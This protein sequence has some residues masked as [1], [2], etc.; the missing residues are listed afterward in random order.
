MGLRWLIYFFLA[1]F[2]SV[3]PAQAVHWF[4]LLPMCQHL[5]TPIPHCPPITDYISPGTLHNSWMKILV[6]LANK[7]QEHTL[8]MI[9]KYNCY[10][11]KWWNIL[12]YLYKLFVFVG[13]R[14]VASSVRHISSVSES[15][16]NNLWWTNETNHILLRMYALHYKF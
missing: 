4:V 7:Y 14:W 10:S 8:I 3:P 13:F 12:K 1:Y 15:I 9:C 2:S 5:P 16:N 11:H 6:T